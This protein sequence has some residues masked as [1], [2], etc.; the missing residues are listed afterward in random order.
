MQ[1]VGVVILLVSVFAVYYMLGSWPVE[2]AALVLPSATAALGFGLLVGP[3]L[4]R[5]SRRKPR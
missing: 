3:A 4:R 5:S 2:L 1:G